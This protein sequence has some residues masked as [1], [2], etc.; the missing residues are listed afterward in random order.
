MG[1]VHGA[2]DM[3]DIGEG[4][5]A[6][7]TTLGTAGCSALRLGPGAGV[8]FYRSYEW[9][10]AVFHPTLVLQPLNVGSG[11]HWIVLQGVIFHP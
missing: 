6:R 4:R 9:L 2:A 3:G 11:L 8:A 7:F 1:W 10:T 5:Q